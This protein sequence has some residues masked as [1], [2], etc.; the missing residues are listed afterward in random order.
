MV[1]QK[2]APT[3]T[4]AYSAASRKTRPIPRHAEPSENDLSARYSAAYDTQ[5]HNLKSST[6]ARQR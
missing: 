4:D 3:E 2:W 5:R 1:Q 6:I